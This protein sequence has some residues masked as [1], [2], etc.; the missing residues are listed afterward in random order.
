MKK[1]PTKRTRSN[2]KRI[3]PVLKVLSPLYPDYGKPIE[4]TKVPLG[5]YIKAVRQELRAKRWADAADK[6]AEA[7]QEVL[8]SKN[9]I[10]EIDL[11]ITR[12]QRSKAGKTPRKKHGWRKEYDWSVIE[13]R[14]H[15]IHNQYKSYTR[16]YVATKIHDELKWGKIP[17]VRSIEEHLKFIPSKRIRKT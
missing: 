11:E 17:T 16:H 7:L 15:T 3:E 6:E 1:K 4:E 2:K 10:R 12:L 9:K 14:G 5:E 13:E 8:E